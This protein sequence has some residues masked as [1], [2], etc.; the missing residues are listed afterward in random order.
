MADK[1]EKHTEKDITFKSFLSGFLVRVT[2]KVLV[3]GVVFVVTLELGEKLDSELLSL[4]GAIAFLGMCMTI[5]QALYIV[6]SKKTI[7]AEIK[8]KS[9]ERTKSKGNLKNVGIVKSVKERLEDKYSD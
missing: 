4:V 3:L 8:Q 1:N 2:L 7:K 5:L 9:N 6:F